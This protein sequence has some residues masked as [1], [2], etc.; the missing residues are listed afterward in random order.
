MR[1]FDRQSTPS[2]I[3]SSA[4][5][6]LPIAANG[7]GSYSPAPGGLRTL[8]AGRKSV[9]QAALV[10]SLWLASIGN[11]ALW[12]S[13]TN[14][15]LSSA[16]QWILSLSLGAAIACVC[17]AI[18]SLL[19]WGR[20]A[21]PVMLAVCWVAAFAGYFML[22]YGIAIDASML[23]NVMQTDAREAA[24]LLHWSLFVTVAAIALP[25][26]WW[27]LRTPLASN[28]GWRPF[29]RQLATVLA[30][31]VAMAAIVLA[32]FQPISSAM[33]NHTQLRFMMNPLSS[34]Y[35]AGNLIAQQIHH[36]DTT[37]YP[38]GEDA[39]LGA[40]YATQPQFP[41]YVL[42]VGETGRAGNF[43]LYGYSRP[44]TPMLSAR[45]DLAVARDAWSCGTSTAVSVPCMFSHLG[46]TGQ[47]SSK[48]YQ[49]L[50]DV[51]QHAGLAV[52]WVDNQSGCKG[53]CD[54]VLK[55]GTQATDSKAAAANAAP[56][57]HLTPEQTRALCTD[58]E[59]VDMALMEGLD[60]RINALPAVQRQHGVVLV[61]HQMGSHG[62][63]YFKRSQQ[64]D[65]RFS[66][67]CTS[68]S[69]QSCDQPSLIN[70][71]DNSIVATDRM[72]ASLITWLEQKGQR[73]PTA[74]M[75]V[76]DHGESL[77]E[78]NIYLHGLPYSV[79]PD[80]QKHI[81]WITWLSP[82]MQERT[83]ISTSCLQQ[84]VGNTKI[85]HDNY[86]H[87]V[88]GLTDV[89]T[90]LRDAKLDI[91]ASCAHS[92]SQNTLSKI[93]PTSVKTVTAAE[94]LAPSLLATAPADAATPQKA[95][96]PKPPVRDRS[97]AARKPA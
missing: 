29:L 20:A 57:I 35:A 66:P 55:A 4:A 11:L 70:A 3:P 47:S 67:E 44:T 48:S 92:Q 78:N 62:P 31:I 16:Q 64:Q 13:I 89:Q 10:I 80:V 9:W 49:N 68:V 94:A 18:F 39:K 23:V 26:T 56:S 63:A 14:L 54:R 75:Y 79:A 46:R 30:A 21:K 12:K 60:D 43:G 77:G 34:L 69:L 5:N 8:L 82:L 40:S 22:N 97:P 7:Q 19:C 58:G 28:T 85:S 6:D 38:I 53:V 96:N 41:I 76:A 61:L 65:K 50:L 91:F 95:S 25:P 86:F 73:Q 37:I 59:C 81:P 72:L 51:L 52:L 15:P 2:A 24:D 84:A 42:V 83:G 90:G 36:R 33:R 32:A 17:L 74:M 87:S 27:L 45:Q 1:I 93:E 71:Y 88:L